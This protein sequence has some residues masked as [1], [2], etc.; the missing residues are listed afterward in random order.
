MKKKESKGII[1]PPPPGPKL[2]TCLV[3]ECSVIEKYYC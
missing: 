2:V 3:K 1:S